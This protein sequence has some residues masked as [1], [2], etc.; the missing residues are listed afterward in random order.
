MYTFTLNLRIVLYTH[1][2]TQIQLI[3]TE[4]NISKNNTRK[5]YMQSINVTHREGKTVC[6]TFQEKLFFKNSKEKKVQGERKAAG[7]VINN[8]KNY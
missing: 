2:H 1:K 3:K 6:F 4:E 5:W 8:L 7:K